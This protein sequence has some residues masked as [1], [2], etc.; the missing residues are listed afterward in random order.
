MIGYRL[1]KVWVF[2]RIKKSETLVN[3]RFPWCGK[4]DLKRP[5]TINKRQKK[6]KKPYFSRVS[7]NMR[8]SLKTMENG[9]YI[10]NYATFP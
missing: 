4:Q 8:E 3:Q 1:G 7:G 5:G 10:H 9:N 6:S 2:P